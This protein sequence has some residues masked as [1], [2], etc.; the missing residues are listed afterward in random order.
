MTQLT[1]TLGQIRQKEEEYR[2]WVDYFTRLRTEILSKVIPKAIIIADDG[3]VRYKY[4]QDIENAL[5]E[6]DKMEEHA[7]KSCGINKTIEL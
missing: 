5:K 4:S 7:M 1:I 2:K 6:I 3:N